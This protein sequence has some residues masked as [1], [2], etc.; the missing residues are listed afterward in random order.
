MGKLL[1]KVVACRLTYLIVKSL[2]KD[3]RQLSY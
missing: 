1:E 2:S 3:K